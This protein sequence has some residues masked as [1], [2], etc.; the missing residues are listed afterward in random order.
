MA[1]FMHALCQ[2]AQE[3]FFF[4]HTRQSSFDLNYSMNSQ[5]HLSSDSSLI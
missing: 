2:L 1:G 5:D 4:L 3:S